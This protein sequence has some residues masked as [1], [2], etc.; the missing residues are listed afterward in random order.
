MTKITGNKVK[1]LINGGAAGF[2]AV[3]LFGPDQGLA[4][5]YRGAL[6]KA[7]VDNPHDPFLVVE[8]S[9]AKIKEEPAR[10]WDEVTAQSMIGGKRVVIIQSATDGLSSVL[11]DFLAD[12]QGDA[13]V[14]V[15]AG[16]LGLRSSLRKVFDAAKTGAS[17]GCYPDDGGNLENVIRSSLKEQGFNINAETLHFLASRMGSD[18][19]VTRMELEKL[20]LYCA[21]Q[22]DITLA[23]AEASIGDS[24][25]SSLDMVIDCALTGQVVQMERGL[26]RAFEEGNQAVGLVRMLMRRIDRLDIVR[27]QMAK[28]RAAGQAIKDL[29]PPVNFKQVDTFRRQADIWSPELLKRAREIALEAEIA[30]KSSGGLPETQVAR[31]FLRLAQ[32]ARQ[33]LRR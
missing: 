1:S 30:C 8:L 12:P 3:L 29:R 24:A 5:E 27:G 11:K 7:V 28:G 14:I 21:G 10:F 17:I 9:V 20:S 33:N 32:A 22:S 15:Q 26:N 4:N 2:A 31:A 25:L 13:L 23:D 18:R 16:D 6:T 19:Q